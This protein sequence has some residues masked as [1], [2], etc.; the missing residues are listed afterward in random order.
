MP[1]GV[2]R[3]WFDSKGYGFIIP[4]VQNVGTRYA[5]DVF[6]HRHA[7]QGALYLTS[8]D[9]VSF[10]WGWNVKKALYQAS[11]VSILR[12]SEWT[13]APWEHSISIPQTPESGMK[14]R[15]S[16]SDSVQ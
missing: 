13:A 16:T 4:D 15:W 6:V 5:D 8:G 11:N 10:D 14:R 12:S 2:V 9:R 7:V 3:S 1:R